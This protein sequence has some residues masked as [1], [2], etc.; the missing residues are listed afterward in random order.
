MSG[1]LKLSRFH[2]HNE[3]KHANSEFLVNYLTSAPSFHSNYRGN[4]PVS[5]HGFWRINSISIK[6]ALQSRNYSA[7]STIAKRERKKKEEMKHI[8]HAR[9]HTC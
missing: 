1:A 8:A 7:K 4:K 6:A 9:T 2:A 3:E 5:T